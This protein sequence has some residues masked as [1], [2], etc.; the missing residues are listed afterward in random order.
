MLT[1]K[2]LR[3]VTQSKRRDFIYSLMDYLGYYPAKI[4][5]ETKITANQITILW[6]VGQ[7]ISSLFVMYGTYW[8]MLLGVVSFQLFF[9]LDCTD[10]IVARYKKQFSLNGVYLDYLGHYI[11]NP[12]LLISLGIGVFRM[13]GD[14][15]AV[16][17]GILAALFF[18]LNKATTLN[19]LWYSDK[20][21]R[22]LIETSFEKSLLKNQ[23][24]LLYSIFAFFRLEYIFNFMFFGVLS[25]YAYYVL[26]VYTI[27][28]FL[29]LVRKISMQLLSNHNLD[30][31]KGYLK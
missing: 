14:V 21:H 4:L 7:V 13:N 16:F 25:G 12:L 22:V 8:S 5:I 17:I 29:E 9:I 30:K 28:F 1:I 26:I 19:L 6:I 10:G 31:T 2:E 3:A 27:F 20:D 24:T 15:Y 18:L 23:R 11:N